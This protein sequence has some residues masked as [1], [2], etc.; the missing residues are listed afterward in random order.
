MSTTT[1]GPFEAKNERGETGF[2]ELCRKLKEHAEYVDL[3]KRERDQAQLQWL[4][5][6]HVLIRIADSGEAA[7]DL[8]A[9]ARR[10]VDESNLS[11]LTPKR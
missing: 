6:R 3:L 11:A 10:A 5:L 8:R 2:E 7:S 9:I 1:I 4:K